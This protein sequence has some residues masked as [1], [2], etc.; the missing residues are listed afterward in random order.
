MDLNDYQKEAQKTAAYP[1]EHRVTYPVLGL[2]GEAG[3][4]A[5]TYKK[6]LRGDTTASRDKLL[7]EMGDVLWYL[8]AL[9]SDLGVDLE[10]IAHDNLAKLA[11]RAERGTI[12]GDGDER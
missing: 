6:F 1:R 3:E 11:D 2:A 7:S 5:D 9:A 10:Q 4:V 8:A 12:Q